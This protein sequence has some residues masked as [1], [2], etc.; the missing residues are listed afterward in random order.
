MKSKRKI[1][2]EI[3]K[4]IINLGEA[5]PAEDESIDMISSSGYRH[6][7]DYAK[8]IFAIETE[9]EASSFAPRLFHYTSIDALYSIL[10]NGELWLG[11]TE[12]AN[13]ISEM[14]WFLSRF[15]REGERVFDSKA[16]KLFQ[17]L[18]KKQLEPIIGFSES[19]KVEPL[20]PYVMC[21]SQ[22]EDD[23]AQWERYAAN[24]TGVCLVFNTKN[25]FKMFLESNILVA[26]VRYVKD[27]DEAESF[28][29][30]Q[31]MLQ[32]DEYLNYHSVEDIIED[33][34]IDA[35]TYKDTSFRSEA[36]IRAVAIEDAYN[37]YPNS[38]KYYCNKKAIKR[39]FVLN[40]LKACETAHLQ[41][42]D[43]LE[44]IVLGPRTSQN[45]RVLGAFCKNCGY[46]KLAGKIQQSNCPL[47]S[48][49]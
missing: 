31:R 21:F 48:Q 25:M 19:T 41:P 46:T 28:R 20:Y 6:I 12:S 36:E 27:I 7:I 43:V 4:S 8:T 37:T 16:N 3:I 39:C 15:E 35:A 17:S 33:I 18:Y 2:A 45:A 11:N 13:D 9:K 49:G 1:K 30:L 42:Q 29:A 40:F 10:S 44:G 32:T 22:N 38:I 23:A 14:R 24:A 5:V 26:P 47:N 34:Y